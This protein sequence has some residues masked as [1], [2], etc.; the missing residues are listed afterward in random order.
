MARVT[1]IQ[2]EGTYPMAK[3]KMWYCMDIETWKCLGAIR[4][5]EYLPGFWV[6]TCFVSNTVY[7]ADSMEDAERIVTDAVSGDSNV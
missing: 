6:H 5:R 1:F 2:V 7:P 3:D 4:A